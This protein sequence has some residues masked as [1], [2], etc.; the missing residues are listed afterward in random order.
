MVRN[1]FDDKT[2]V[3]IATS[4]SLSSISVIRISGEEALDV[5]DKIFRGINQRPFMDIRPFSIRYGHIL[6]EDESVIDEVLV[7]YF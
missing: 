6:K 2:I 7:S 1:M 5:T 4:A 3:G